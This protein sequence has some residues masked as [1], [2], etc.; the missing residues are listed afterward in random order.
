MFKT[1]FIKQVNLFRFITAN[2]LVTKNLM[3][4]MF[5]I[6]YFVMFIGKTNSTEAIKK[7]CSLYPGPVR[8]Q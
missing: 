2:S 8:V 4:A 1:I 7:I 5:Y 3:D 6:A